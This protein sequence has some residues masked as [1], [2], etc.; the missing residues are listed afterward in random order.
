MERLLRSA[1][2]ALLMHPWQRWK[3]QSGKENGST[4]TRSLSTLHKNQE[5]LDFPLL[6]NSATFPQNLSWVETTACELVPACALS[7][8]LS[9]LVKL[10]LGAVDPGAPRRSHINEEFACASTGAAWPASTVL[11]QPNTLFYWLLSRLMLRFAVLPTGSSH[12]KTFIY[13]SNTQLRKQF[14]T[15]RLV[16]DGRRRSTAKGFQVF[17]SF[18]SNLWNMKDTLCRTYITHSV[19]CWCNY[20]HVLPSLGEMTLWMCPLHTSCLWI[21]VLG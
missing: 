21:K 18:L 12:S 13:T 14:Q 8:V 6:N 1:P 4:Q 5:D 7:L 19:S 16:C 2:E 3:C 17:P 9:S 20:L 11:T 15:T 10:W